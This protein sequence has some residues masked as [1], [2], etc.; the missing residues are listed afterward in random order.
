MHDFADELELWDKVRDAM[1]M[2]SLENL[3]SMVAHNLGVSVV[4][5]ICLPDAVFASLRKI[6]L[7]PTATARELGVLTRG[8]CSKIKLVERLL[9]QIRTTITVEAEST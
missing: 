1:E 2:G 4:P 8:D 9:E 3:A 5:N 7:G 6:P